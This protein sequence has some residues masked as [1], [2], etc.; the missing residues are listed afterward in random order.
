MICDDVFEQS[1]GDLAADAAEVAQRRGDCEVCG[2]LDQC[3]ALALRG[4]TPLTARPGF[5]QGI[6]DRLPESSIEP[7]P[8]ETIEA[9]LSAFLDQELEDSR[10]DDI[11]LHLAACNDCTRELGSIRSLTGLLGRTLSLTAP[12]GFALEVFG[13]LD[14]E[15]ESKSQAKEAPK[16]SGKAGGGQA[17]AREPI[18]IPPARRLRAP[19][20]L[21]AAAA[22][23]LVA[24]VGVG[25]A[26]RGSL[27][28]DQVATRGAARELEAKSAPGSSF[29]EATG[30]PPS[31]LQ[32][33]GESAKTPPPG[34]GNRGFKV[35][36]AAP[37]AEA[38]QELAEDSKDLEGAEQGQQQKRLEAAT[39]GQAWGDIKDSRE[40]RPSTLN[41]VIASADLP[42]TRRELDAL[43]EVRFRQTRA[44]A[45]SRGAR[46]RSGTL[47][48]TAQPKLVEAESPPPSQPE[49][50]AKPR[51]APKKEPQDSLPEERPKRGRS[52]RP[53]RR[54]AAP[55]SPSPAAPPPK[56]E[57]PRGR[58]TWT[59]DLAESELPTLLAR[60]RALPDS[61]LRSSSSKDQD[62][63][64]RGSV[65]TD[66]P[67]GDK[68]AAGLTPAQGGEAVGGKTAID[69][70]LKGVPGARA[71][72]DKGGAFKNRDRVAPLD[73]ITLRDGWVLAGRITAES[74]AE[75][76]LDSAGRQVTIARDRIDA[77]ERAPGE[78]RIKVTIELAAGK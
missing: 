23:V 75:V 8:C 22:A 64:G 60:L 37:Q 52:R 6:L 58:T 5:C 76:V 24:A 54:P 4:L 28:P 51:S 62:G 41:L 21:G 10:A 3:V 25:L 50:K 19:L 56:S 44:N 63:Q 39:R 36:A 68:A 47:P 33:A 43:L 65:E 49:S 57:N 9:E 20:W 72:G 35:P 12:Q 13:R 7:E 17:P 38:V 32:R 26:P 61:T 45:S 31:A 1:Q 55:G 30:E 70:L 11:I 46:E 78:R 48:T 40:A 27:A 53:A 74:T 29:D 34:Y 69:L 42:R 15:S 71:K 16:S 59:L 67:R 2:A 77:I 14:A 18:R 66:A 73:R